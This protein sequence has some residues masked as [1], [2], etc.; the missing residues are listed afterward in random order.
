M[1]NWCVSFLSSLTDTKLP[2]CKSIVKGAPLPKELS[3]TILAIPVAGRLGCHSLTAVVWAAAVPP[4]VPWAA[5]MIA[6]VPANIEVTNINE[7]NL[8]KRFLFNMVILL[9]KIYRVSCF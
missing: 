5:W 2:F 9:I 4:V 8:N 3:K 6:G 1:T 7:L